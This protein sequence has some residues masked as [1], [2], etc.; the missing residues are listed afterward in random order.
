MENNPV[1]IVL[2][3]TVPHCY[4]I[5]LLKKR[6]YHTVLI[7]YTPNPP[8]KA[9]AD[10]HVKES[11]LDKDTVL[12]VA[13]EK[14]AA[15]VIS[16]NVDQANVTCCYVAERLG[17]PRPYSYETALN[18][19]DKK[20]MKQIM[21]DYDIPTSRY[22]V[23]KDL[24]GLQGVQL[25]YPL[26]VKPADSNSAK[27]VKRVESED[28]FRKYL[29]EALLFSRNGFAIVE[30]FKEG[31]E[32]SA[33]G[34]VVNGQAKLI[35]HQE[36]ISV[37]DGVDRVIK[38]Y[39]SL[40][41]SR[42]SEHAVT[43]AEMILTQIA[44]AFG[45]DNTPLFFQGIVQGDEISVIEFAPRVGGGISF[46]TIMDGTGF[47]MI[48]AGL[49]SFLFFSIKTDGW[50]AMNHSYA[51][52]QIYGENGIYDHSEGVERLLQDGIVQSV[53]FYKAKGDVIDS[54]RASSSRIGVMV[55]SGSSQEELRRK[56]ATAFSTLDT[57]D[58]NGKSIIRRDLNLD[59]LWE[60][61]Y[62]NA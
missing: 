15:L 54:N 60:T 5:H 49:D 4:L 45:L 19:T 47:D 18:V 17:L 27:G 53:S 22:V 28:E 13:R 57:F 35:M 25:H 39:S 6:G 30:E 12:Q 8:A 31:K 41:P 10:E 1:A 21:W 50:H 24:N 2:G 3:G 16:T 61:A 42:I 56:I 52:N 7:D 34:V 62:S 58:I 11:T 51:V 36:R 26:I 14:N 20:R 23:V 29:P 55:V 9:F 33:Y 43:K 37:Y 32:I 48:S 46:R 38:C 40:A 44:Q 59:A